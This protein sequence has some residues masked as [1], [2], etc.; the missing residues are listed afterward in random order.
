MDRREFLKI[1]SKILITVG[2]VNFFSFEELMA[3]D[4]GEI[5]KPDLIWLH[6]MSCDG[7]STSLLNS[8]VPMLDILTRFTNIIFHPTIMAGTGENALRILEEHNS[9]NLIMVLEGSIPLNMPHACMMGEKFIE[10]WVYLTAK[11]SKMAIAV[12]TC[13]VFNGITEM[14]GMHTGASTL[15]YFLEKRNIGTPVVNLPTC[16]MKPHHFLYTL[17]YYIKHKS[18]PSTD[19]E[20]RPLRFFGNTVHERCIYYNDY[21]EKIFAKKVGER[22]C[23]F[24]LGCQGP[25]T[26]SD[27]IKSEG[28][29]DRYNCIKS[30]HPCIGCGSENFP[31]KI[32]FKRSDDN[33]ELTKY[34]DFKRI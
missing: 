17:F 25:V 19:L 3:L 29:F 30:G 20:N 7:C 23:L 5:Q 26:T 31:R 28:D 27:C 22:G 4:N 8:E 9:E 13:A 2:G 15:K 21:Q 24:E 32:M 14:D 33:R 11:K 18:I 1:V 6:A 34:K 10:D 16:P 12:G